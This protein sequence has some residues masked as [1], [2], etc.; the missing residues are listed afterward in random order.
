MDCTK[1]TELMSAVLDGECTA[2]ERRALDSHLAVCPECAA[3]FEIL[4]ANAKAARE[5]DCEMPAGLKE[6]ILNNL[7]AQEQPKKQGKVIH[8]KRWIPVAAAACLVLVVS[9]VPF[10]S[11]GGNAAPEMA[12]A[13]PSSSSYA[14]DHSKAG[15]TADGSHSYGVAADPAA[16]GA[17]TPAEAPESPSAEPAD[18]AEPAPSE[19]PIPPTEPDYYFF[20]NQRSIRIS[21][22]YRPDLPEPGA[23]II[24]SAAEMD[25]YLTQLTRYDRDGNPVSESKLED[26]RARYAVDG[27]FYET[28]RLLCILIHT[29]NGGDQFRIA[30]QGL[31]G[32]S[33]L[34]EQTMFGG[35]YGREHFLLVAEVGLEFDG[36]DQLET[37]INWIDRTNLR[38]IDDVRCW[39]VGSLGQSDNAAT[40]IHSME[41]LRAYLGRYTHWTDPTAE[42]ISAVYTDE[43]F[44]THTLVAITNVEAV[45]HLKQIPVLVT[46]SRVY[47]YRDDVPYG[48]TC[49][50]VW[51]TLIEVGEVMET[52]GTLELVTADA[53]LQDIMFSSYYPNLSD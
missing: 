12:N 15:V 9:L 32:D 20:E 11:R 44:K 19:E 36:G 1:Y 24:G 8:W 46:N 40:V 16:P 27:W 6:R 49:S 23:Q 45:T 30:P 18:P 39:H 14:Y 53:S 2:E 13:D 51:L 17:Y 33:V 10:S 4:S 50:S 47:L 7:P 43:F 21:S 38:K 25:T 3:L 52:D 26:L 42:D 29:R 37:T 5:L 31:Q 48:N 35:T 34:V 28:N 41:D 22:H